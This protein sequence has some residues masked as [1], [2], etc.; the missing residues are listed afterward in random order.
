MPI[1]PESRPSLRAREPREV[2]VNSSLR[3]REI[4]VESDPALFAITTKHTIEFRR[5]C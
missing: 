1:S 3:E 2:Q 5:D 4:A